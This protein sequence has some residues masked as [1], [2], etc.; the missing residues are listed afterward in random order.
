MALDIE[1]NNI[2]CGYSQGQVRVYKLKDNKLQ[3][4]NQFLAH[5]SG[6]KS[7]ALSQ[8]YNVL[9]TGSKVNTLVTLYRMEVAGYGISQIN[10]SKK[11]S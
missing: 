7:L 8:E 5:L 2:Y 3:L 11:L 1:S 10:N 9:A 6:I 4:T